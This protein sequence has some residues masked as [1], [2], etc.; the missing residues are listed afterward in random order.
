MTDNQD[1]KETSAVSGIKFWGASLQ[2]RRGAA[3]LEGGLLRAVHAMARGVSLA[4]VLVATAARSLIVCW[5]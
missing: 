5:F 1:G 2:V 4:T 3:S